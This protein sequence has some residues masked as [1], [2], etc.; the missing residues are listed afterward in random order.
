MSAVL[1]HAPTLGVLVTCAAFGLA[2]ATY[3]RHRAP[4]VGPRPPRASPPRRLPEVE[5]RAVL[6]VLHEPRF[7]DL[8]PAEVFA[9]L[10][11]EGRYLCSSRTMH[12]ILAEHAELRERR[13]QLRRP[14]YA[15]PEL[16]ATGPNQLWSWD[17]TKLHGPAKWT[18]FY[19]YVIL[20]VFSRYVV[21]WMVAHREVTVQE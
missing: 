19:L 21:G 13:N 14:T 9:S 15:K 8:A 6:D 12:R 1:T 7:A 20:D 10:L 2:V 3:Y 16:L 5:R 4:V 11:E 18:D 17:I